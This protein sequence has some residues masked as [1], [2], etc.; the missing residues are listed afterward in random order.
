MP[1]RCCVPGCKNNYNSSKKEQGNV[2]VFTFPKDIE[3]R[4]QWLKCIHREDFIPSDHSVV[5]ID[6]FEEKFIVRK[7]TATRPDGSV[8]TVD[9][10][11]LKLSPDAFPTRFPNQPKYLSVELPPKR[12]DPAE[13]AAAIEMLEQQKKMQKEELNEAK[14]II[15]NYLDIVNKKETI[16]TM[17]CER[18]GHWES[19]VKK[20]CAIF[21]NILL[22][23]YSKVK[24]DVFSE[25]NN[26]NK[27]D[28]VKSNKKRKTD[29]L[30]ST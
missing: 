4:N 19:V 11:R 20:V 7:D 1:S 25:R 27:D 26:K 13:R 17:P 6:H 18:D 30:S 21:A 15:G 16:L 2:S 14:D 24:N 5:C 22:N 28:S 12:R 10:K 29:K 23:N 3:R 8:L 9:R